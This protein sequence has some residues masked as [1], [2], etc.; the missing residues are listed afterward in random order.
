MFGLIAR[1]KQA[2]AERLRREK[3]LEEQHAR[4][5]QGFREVDTSVELVAQTLSG[6]GPR[7]NVLRIGDGFYVERNADGSESIVLLEKGQ[8][9]ERHTA[10]LDNFKASVGLS[11]SPPE[12]QA[13]EIPRVEIPALNLPEIPALHFTAPQPPKP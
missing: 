12:I 3:L 9:Q 1:I 8:P 10:K 4:I 6:R 2:R 13:P 11:I 5:V 7:G